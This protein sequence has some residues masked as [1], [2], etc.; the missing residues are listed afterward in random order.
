MGAAIMSCCDDSARYLTIGCAPPVQ[1]PCRSKFHGP[2]TRLTAFRTDQAGSCLSTTRNG[3]L[4]GPL[5]GH[6][7]T[8]SRDPACL[9][10]VGAPSGTPTRLPRWGH[11]LLARAAVAYFLGH[12]TP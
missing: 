12:T 6:L 1:H 3:F 9:T 10:G 8:A 2:R 7:Q 4:R 11:P 5:R